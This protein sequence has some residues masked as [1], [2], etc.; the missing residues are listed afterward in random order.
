MKIKII[1]LFLIL[2]FSFNI[3]KC[4]KEFKMLTLLTAQVD[5]LG[6]NN[7]INQGRIEVA[8][9]MNIEDSR[10]L[11]V[12]GF[13]ETFKHLLPI[14][15]NDDI[16]L[17]IC[18][19]SGHLQ[20]CRAI[21]E[22]YINSTTIKTQF[23]VRGSSSPTRN[24]IYISYNYASANYISGYF[25]ALFSKTGK[26]GFVSPGQAAN[27]NDS[28]VYAF[29]I[30][31]RQVNPDIKFYYYNIGN[32]LD[33]DK[34]V[35]A[36]NDLLDM[37][38]D[39]VGNTLDDFSTGDAS[40]ARGF[41]AIGTNGFPQRH[42]YGEN[43][44]YSYSYNWT[45]F[46]LPIAESVKSGNTNNS[47]WYADF[48]FDE[49]K[50][51]FHLDYG[52]EVNQ[53]VLDKMNTEIDYLKS[54]D[55]MIHPYYCNDLIP[56][57][58]KEN[59][60]KLA[61]VSDI[62]LP[63]GC[64]THQTFLT[65]N[66]PFPGMTFL[67]NYKIKLVEVEFSQSIQYGFSITTGAL[68]A[69]T[70]IMML[71]IVKYKSTPS[72]RSASP[73][74]LNFILA[75]GIIVYIG[76][77]VWVGPASNHQCNARLWLVTLGFSTLIG[78]L[79]VK[80]FRIWLIFDN[81]ELKSISITNYQLFPWVGACLVINI[82]LMSILTSVGDLREIDAQGIDSL[83]KY[84]FMKVCK[85]NSSGAS[86]LY[87]ILAYFAALLLVGVFV[88]WKIRIVDIQEFNESK[89]IA[90]TLY[91]ISFCLFVIVPLMISPQDKQ[92]ETIVLCTAGLFITTA[93]LLIIFTPKFWRVFT[94]GDG[95]T[96]DMFRKKQSNVATAR[97]ESSKSSSGPK[98]NRRGNLVSNDFT[99][100]ETSISE[101][102]VNVVAGAVLAEFTDDTISEFDDNNIEQDNN[103]NDND[104]NNNNNTGQPNDEKVEEKQQ[105]D[106]EE[107]KNQ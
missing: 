86:T 91:A 87:T 22:M 6:F 59:N 65:I 5:D 64:V 68:I 97:A 26:I 69:I 31:A 88:S 67:G 42:V 23:L 21:A 24:L 41:P 105:N 18:S 27:N 89:A 50:N 37:G 93:A 7:M 102:K 54:T 73:I 72:I 45:K 33:V 98:L 19:S 74:F 70:I 15:Q 8:K 10:L 30:G 96:N 49:N 4:D 39:V 92:S 71:G 1:F 90:N 16:D 107:D 35:A 106:T 103:D 40:I 99:D 20:A 63:I 94:L 3:I 12:D 75:G 61:N 51:F 46:F 82:I 13:N 36:T 43:V 56:K 84:E 79:V 48:N 2:I 38:C 14:V 101:K 85:M 52:F 80:N 76:I 78:S 83:G 57:Y 66:K 47:Q 28:F 29:W 58:A 62:S 77:I 17:V 9:G 60:L 53:S 34:T 25:A 32:Y 44:I 55:R 11:V 95:G 100:T 81:P 104:N